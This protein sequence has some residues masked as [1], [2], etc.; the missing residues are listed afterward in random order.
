MA[1]LPEK[2]RLQDVEISSLLRQA[3]AGDSRAQWTLFQ[4]FRPFLRD[5]AA[6]ELDP[7][8]Q[9]KLSSSDLV[10]ESIVEAKLGFRAFRGETVDEL[11]GW[12]KGIVC[13]N[14]N[15]ARRTFFADKRNVLR[16][17][18][19]GPN[20]DEDLLHRFD[21]VPL[22][23]ASRKETAL[24]VQRAILKLGSV[25]QQVIRLRHGD[26][27]TFREIGERLAMS[28]EAVRKVWFRSIKELRL[29]LKAETQ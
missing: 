28:D 18:A 20:Q 3:R 21:S 6:E 1:K 2:E 12:L 19:L 23:E 25:Q 10:Q 7:E 8:L 22:D 14:A 29:L 16:E 5:L 26:A 24:A 13:N 15:D 9:A 4:Q 11:K 17:A 27:L